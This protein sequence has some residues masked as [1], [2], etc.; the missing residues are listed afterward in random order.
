MVLIHTAAKVA[1]TKRTEQEQRPTPGVPEQFQQRRKSSIRLNRKSMGTTAQ[2]AARQ[3]LA[4]LPDGANGSRLSRS[5][6]EI[7]FRDQGQRRPRNGDQRTARRPGLK[8]ESTNGFIHIGAFRRYRILAVMA[9][10]MTSSSTCREEVRHVIAKGINDRGS[11]S[12]WALH[13]TPQDTL[14]SNGPKPSPHGR[15]PGN[16]GRMTWMMG[17]GKSR[18]QQAFGF[19]GSTRPDYEVRGTWRRCAKRNA[20]GGGMG[21]LVPVHFEPAKKNQG[22]DI[23]RRGCDPRTA[24]LDPDGE[25]A[26]ENSNVRS[27]NRRLMEA[28]DHHHRQSSPPPALAASPHR[29]SA[30]SSPAPHP[31]RRA[32]STQAA[33]VPVFGDTATELIAQ[34]AWERMAGI[35]NNGP[36]TRA[37]DRGNDLEAVVAFSLLSRDWQP[38]SKLRQ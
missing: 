2:R 12:S 38:P 20:G 13:G 16:Q 25:Q 24:M 28:P 22:P 10:T 37:T 26:A 27:Q 36:L 7:N 6:V 29:T 5:T 30:S 18:H 15:V 35:T 33:G 32:E 21:H 9:P 4:L 3:N 19:A 1:V 14:T 34:K 8:Y 17:R 31:F 11:P 23:H